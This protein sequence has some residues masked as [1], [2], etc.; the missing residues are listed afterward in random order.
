MTPHVSSPTTEQPYTL[1]QYQVAGIVLATRWN[2]AA[3]KRY[4]LAGSGGD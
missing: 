2:I 3:T 4:A 1:E